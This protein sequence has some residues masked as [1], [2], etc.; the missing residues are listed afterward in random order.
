MIKSEKTLVGFFDVH[1]Y[2]S[3]IREHSFDDAILKAQKLFPKLEKDLE[4]FSCDL[5]LKHII[6]SDSIIVTPDL[7]NHEL[8]SSFIGFFL[9]FCAILLF[10]CIENNLPLRGAIG[11]G[12]FYWDDRIILG[13]AL[14][15]AVEFEKEQEWFGAVI[16]PSALDVIQ[17]LISGD[18]NDIQFYGQFVKKGGIPWKKEKEENSRIDKNID[19]F[20]IV[21]SYIINTLP[22]DWT[23]YLPK[24]LDPGR[25]AEKIKNSHCIYSKSV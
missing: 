12:E 3:F 11:G 25:C 17:P 6:F 19:Y 14:I 2:S 21:L 9:G 4:S 10:R 22:K 1:A 18:L 15:D 8:D 20:Y 13:K 5:R 23:E 7:T 16:A 24:Y